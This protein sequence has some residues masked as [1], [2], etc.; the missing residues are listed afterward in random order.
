MDFNAVDCAAVVAEIEQA[1]CAD[2][3]NVGRE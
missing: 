2:G 1:L 3:A